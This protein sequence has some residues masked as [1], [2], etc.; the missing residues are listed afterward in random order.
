MVIMSISNFFTVNLPLP[1]YVREARF[2]NIGGYKRTSAGERSDTSRAML[3][4]AVSGSMPDTA[5]SFSLRSILSALTNARCSIMERSVMIQTLYE[6]RQQFP[7]TKKLS[8]IGF[9][10]NGVA[11]FNLSYIC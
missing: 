6:E 8:N 3:C 10:V 4:N 11:L 5:F 1:S 2:A 7:F 9:F